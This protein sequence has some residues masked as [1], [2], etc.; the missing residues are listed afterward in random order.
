MGG[1]LPIK[2][3]FQI[4]RIII[5]IITPHP[6]RHPRPR[7]NVHMNKI[8][9]HG[10]ESRVTAQLVKRVSKC[11]A[12]GIP[13]RLALAGQGVTQYAYERHLRRHPELAA[14]HEAAKVTFLNKTFDM[15]LSRPG[16]LVRWLLERRHSDLFAPPAELASTA[17]PAPAAPEPQKPKQT[18]AGVPED[19]LEQARRDALLK[20]GPSPGE[21]REATN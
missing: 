18:I 17:Q 4:I 13:V 11:V 8:I 19:E 6:H 21:N 1:Q 14:I 15:I 9:R 10:P 3:S 20:L 16:P 7:F 12:R 2:P 5:E